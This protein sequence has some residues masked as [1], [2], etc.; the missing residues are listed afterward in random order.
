MDSSS[1]SKVRAGTVAHNICLGRARIFAEAKPR[2]TKVRRDERAVRDKTRQDPRK[3]SGDE[4]TLKLY[5]DVDKFLRD[6]DDFFR[7]FAI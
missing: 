2:A 4:D 6:N 5:N 3:L 7:G 1:I